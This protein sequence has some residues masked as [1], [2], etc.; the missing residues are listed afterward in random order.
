MDMTLETT[1]PEQQA[2]FKSGPIYRIPSLFFERESK[3]LLAF[4][5]ERRTYSDTSTEKLVMRRGELKVCEGKK[6][7]EWSSLEPVKEARKDGFRPMNPCPVFDKN[8]QTLF[9]FFICVEGAVSDWDQIRE[10]TCKTRLCFI[11]SNDLG[12][13]WSQVTDLTDQLTEIQHWATF[14]TGPGH[15]LQTEEGRLIVPVY[16]YPLPSL[17]LCFKRVYKLQAYAISLYSDDSGKKWAFGTMFQTQS[18]ECEMAECFDDEGKSFMYCNARTV[19]RYRVE[20]SSDHKG[21][22]FETLR[23]GR[24]VETRNGCQGS[25]V[26]FPAQHSEAD[27][28]QKQN[29]WLLFSHPNEKTSRK[30]LGVYLNKSPRNPGAWSA[31]WIINLGC[32]GYSDLAYVDDGWFV[33]LMECGK[34]SEHEQIACK[35]FHY[36]EIEQGTAQ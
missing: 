9:L 10:W 17:P 5:E 33:C 14:A 28:E 22:R 31:P 24:L 2:V 4:A 34:I 30:D 36:S 19:G 7:V 26:A 16:A 18:G 15:G 27:S 25:V 8:S 11:T 32:S 13:T 12:E 21:E 23:G 3:T 20:V 29:K 35:V 6:S 1:T